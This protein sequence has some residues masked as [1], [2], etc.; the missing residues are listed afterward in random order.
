LATDPLTATDAITELPGRYPLQR[1]LDPA[2]LDLAA[3]P[4]F[5]RHR[6]SLHRIHARK[7]SDP[8]LIEFDRLRSLGARFF[9]HQEILALLYEPRFEYRVIDAAILV[10]FPAI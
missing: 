9:E 2:Q 5:H 6:L 3:T 8:A 7:P 1:G 10:Q 4:A